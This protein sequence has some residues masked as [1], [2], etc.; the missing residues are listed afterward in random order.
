MPDFFNYDRHTGLVEY[1]A[2]EGDGKVAIHTTADMQAFVDRVA[3]ARNTRAADKGLFEKGKDFHLYAILD[4]ITIMQLRSKGIDIYK[5]RDKAMM[6]KM[7][8]EINANYP[9]CKVT[10]KMHR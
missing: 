5:T 4:P 9:K 2:E 10:E 8:D 6:R 7:F 3:E 1:I